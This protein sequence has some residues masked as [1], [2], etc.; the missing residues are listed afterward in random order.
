MAEKLEAFLASRHIPNL[1][2]HGP[3]G[4]GK[5]TLLRDFLRRVYGGDP[6]VLKTNVM[7]VNC[8][9][10]NKGIR[11]IR[12]EFKFFA[13]T[14]LQSNY[15]VPFKSIVM[16]NADCLTIDAQTALRRCIELF[17]HSTRFFIVVKDKQRLL[18]PILSRFCA[19]Y[20]PLPSDGTGVN[21][22]QRHLA[23]TFAGL[24][25]S[26]LEPTHDVLHQLFGSP[27]PPT[28]VVPPTQVASPTRLVRELGS[29]PTEGSGSNNDGR[30]SLVRE[31]PCCSRPICGDDDVYSAPAARLLDLA[32]QLYERGESAIDLMKAL[33]TQPTDDGGH[34]HVDPY[35]DPDREHLNLATMCFYKIKGD[36]RHEK[37]LLFYVLFFIHLCS[38]T[39]LKNLLLV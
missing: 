19:I 11:F 2:L 10:G 39:D 26:S 7:V 15:G 6:A 35:P 28:Q 33:T 23:E 3:S 18:N 13:K 34:W 1:I 22:H 20:V 30:A 16:L 37:W 38:K 14:N 12:D 31:L 29:I 21:L 9:H 5:R 24:P 8:S 36:I 27:T 32:T 4:A 17:S 25:S